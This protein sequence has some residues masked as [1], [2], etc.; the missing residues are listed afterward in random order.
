MT[1]IASLSAARARPGLDG[2]GLAA[3]AAAVFAVAWSPIMVRFTDIGPAAS[4]FWRLLLALPVLLAWTRA[5]RIATGSPARRGPLTGEG[6]LAMFAAGIAFAADLAFFHAALPLTSVANASF[7]S[8][9]APVISV[10]AAMALFGEKPSP[11]IVVGLVVALFGVA[12]MTAAHAGGD[13][14]FAL[15]QGDILAVGAALSYAAYL[16]ALKA[17]RAT[18]SAANVTLGSTVVAAVVLFVMAVIEGGP[19][20]PHSV[21]GWL[22]VATIGL[23]CHVLGQGLS[24]VGIGRLPSGVVALML[25]VHPVIAA[26][27]AFFLFGEA[28]SLTQAVGGAMI[29][30]A[31]ALSRR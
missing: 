19:L 10:I 30:G 15:R 7:I 27:I 31:V 9:L 20:V 2:V 4:A 18:R 13:G 11:S 17:A 29:L 16:V 28:L 3:M 25:L 23:V 8:N 5:E 12:V 1:D 14:G 24:A 22:A 26:V 21:S 6:L